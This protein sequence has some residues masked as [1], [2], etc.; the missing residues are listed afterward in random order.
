LVN[1]W[2]SDEC[3][4]LDS[5]Q[6]GICFFTT[7]S[8][9]S[10]GPTLSCTKWVVWP[11]PE[12]ME[13]KGDHKSPRMEWMHEFWSVPHTPSQEE[14]YCSPFLLHSQHPKVLYTFNMICFNQITS[15]NKFSLSVMQQVILTGYSRDTVL[16]CLIWQAWNLRYSRFRD[17]P[18]FHTLF[19][20]FQHE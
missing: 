15:C 16:D 5:R 1:Y 19:L 3:Q 20:C 7:T 2:L 12:R 11:L 17:F 4:G 13:Q 18:L 9:S 10:L 6:A 14:L 8:K